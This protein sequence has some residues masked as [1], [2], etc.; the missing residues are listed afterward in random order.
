MAG[1]RGRSKYR[2]QSK[3]VIVGILLVTFLFCGILFYRTKALQV[4]DSRY[5]ARETELQSQI[6]Q[7]QKKSEELKER[8]AYVQ[9][10]KYIEEIAKSKLGL[11]NPG[12]IL[13]RPN[14]TD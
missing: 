13:L 14:E 2:K 1:I 11:V 12:E 9:T 3:T 4:R 7:E 6:E 5:G 10:K 8:E